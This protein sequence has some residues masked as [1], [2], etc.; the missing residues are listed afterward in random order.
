MAPRLIGIKKVLMR[1]LARPSFAK[2][3]D[4]EVAQTVRAQ[5]S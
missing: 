3:S 2:A 4:G 1:F 5:D